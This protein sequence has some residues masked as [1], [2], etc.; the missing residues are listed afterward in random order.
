M[1]NPVMS[2]TSLSFY[3]FHIQRYWCTQPLGT[4]LAGLSIVAAFVVIAIYPYQRHALQ[5]ATN[6]WQQLHTSSRAIGPKAAPLPEKSLALPLFQSSPLVGTLN[7][8]AEE[9]KLPLDEIQFALDDNANQ[10]YLR[11]RATLTVSA[12]Y[13]SIRRFINRMQQELAE[14]SLDT[15]S[16]ARDDIAAKDLTCDVALSA[17]YRK[18]RHD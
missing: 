10:P 13:P 8:I 3:R 2:L 16:C 17:F 18:V 5:A 12:G 11:Y 1:Q 4:A 9:S 7:R 14:V 6:D 15:I